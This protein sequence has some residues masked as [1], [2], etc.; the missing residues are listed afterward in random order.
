M[1]KYPKEWKC[2][3][4]G[5]APTKYENEFVRTCRIRNHIAYHR[6]AGVEMDGKEEKSRR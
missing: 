6:L 3:Q 4:C 1:R 2:P 5:W